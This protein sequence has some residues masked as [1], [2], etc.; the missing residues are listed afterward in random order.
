MNS[1]ESAKARKKEIIDDI[2]TICKL[3]LKSSNNIELIDRLIYSLLEDNGVK[4]TI[5]YGRS[6]DC[7]E[8]MVDLLEKCTHESIS[9]YLAIFTDVFFDE[10]T[11]YSY[12]E[13]KEYAFEVGYDGEGYRKLMQYKSTWKSLQ[14]EE[15]EMRLENSRVSSLGR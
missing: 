9:D 11:I 1:K 3:K 6:N 5:W 12:L 2:I 13:D 15:L 10:Y 8:V 7:N 14:D 4:L